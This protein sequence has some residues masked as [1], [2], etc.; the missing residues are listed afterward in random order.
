VDGLHR[1][2][3]RIGVGNLPVRFDP[4]RAELV[5]CLP[6]ASGWCAPLGSLCG[7]TIKKLTGPSF[8]RARIR[9][10]NGAPITVSLAT[11]STLAPT[12]ALV[13]TTT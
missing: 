1:R 6:Q 13:S 8:A 10:S 5:Q 3:V 11:T 9:S 2:C 12:C 7:L 4:L